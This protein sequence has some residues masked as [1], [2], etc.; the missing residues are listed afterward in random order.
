MHVRHIW[1]LPY[2]KYSQ[3][4]QKCDFNWGPDHELISKYQVWPL[5]HTG[6]IN[7]AVVVVSGLWSAGTI[8]HCGVVGLQTLEINDRV[9]CCHCG[10]VRFQP[11]AVTCSIILHNSYY[12]NKCMCLGAY[13]CCT[14]TITN[15]IHINFLASHIFLWGKPRASSLKWYNL[16]SP[17]I[18]WTWEFYYY[19]VA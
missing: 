12:P 4:F 13:G 15:T 1:I 5:G 16:S 14:L 6:T 19:P 17:L 3:P 10:L 7:L 18:V 8:F 9:S 2:R 11:L